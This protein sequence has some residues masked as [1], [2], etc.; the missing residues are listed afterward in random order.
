[1][2]RRAKDETNDVLLKTSEKQT[3][4]P[5][6]QLLDAKAAGQAS[7]MGGGGCRKTTS[8]LAG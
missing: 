1:M 3:S 4:Q 2:K 8:S 5:I 6:V 7:G